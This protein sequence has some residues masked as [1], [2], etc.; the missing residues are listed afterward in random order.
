MII[1]IRSDITLI[2]RTILL[3]QWNLLSSCHTMQDWSSTLR[4][5]KCCRIIAR[6][7][8]IT[9]A[10]RPWCDL[11]VTM[12]IEVVDWGSGRSGSAL[13]MIQDWLCPDIAIFLFT[14]ME[15][16]IILHGDPLMWIDLEDWDP[17][18]RRISSKFN[19]WGCRR[20]WRKITHLKNCFSWDIQV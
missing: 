10:W 6:F 17:F 14:I 13:V 8:V 9:I 1:Q 7:F 5:S 12:P 11:L 16:F 20:L 18:A 4:T 15:R 19:V 3:E 2:L